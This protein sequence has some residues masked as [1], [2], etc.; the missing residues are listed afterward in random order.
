MIWDYELTLMG[1]FG[2]VLHFPKFYD[3]GYIQFNIDLRT[4]ITFL[5]LLLWVFFVDWFFDGLGMFTHQ[6]QYICSMM[7]RYR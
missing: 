2:F 1:K 4:E 3:S 6:I 5:C 7:I